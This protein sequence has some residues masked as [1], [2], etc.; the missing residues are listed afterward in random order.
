LRY[1][2]HAYPRKWKDWL[3]T[4]EFWYNTCFHSSLGRAP[5][6]ALYGRQPRTLGIDP[7]AV[8][9]GKLDSWL[10]E[11]CNMHHLIQVHLHRAVSRMKNQADKKRF[12]REFSVGSMVYLKL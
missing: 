9:E 2:I 5:F 8:A 10:T 6:E 12:E 1:F 7:P 4:D 11:R 3:A